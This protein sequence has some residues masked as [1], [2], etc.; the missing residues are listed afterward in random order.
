[1]ANGFTAPIIVALAQW[2]NTGE[3]PS[4]VVW[5]IIGAMAIN[6]AASQL[7]SFLSSSYSD[8]VQ[9]KATGVSGPSP[10][11]VAAAKVTGP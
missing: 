6:G 1:M 3:W 8:Y 4:N 5:V 9:T 11:A 2:A 10:T 7:L